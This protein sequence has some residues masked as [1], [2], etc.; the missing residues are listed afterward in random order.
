M[1]F[2]E[3]KQRTL[4]LLRETQGKGVLDVNGSIAKKKNE[5]RGLFTQ[6]LDDGLE[7]NRRLLQLK[8]LGFGSHINQW[9][10]HCQ[11]E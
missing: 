7:R 5:L 2:E 1:T 3:F 9:S 6:G 10:T 11:S 8:R 4:A